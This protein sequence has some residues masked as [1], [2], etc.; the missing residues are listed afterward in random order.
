MHYF[1]GIWETFGH[2]IGGRKDLK[3]KYH[4]MENSGNDPVG[5]AD[6]RRKST[7]SSST[8]LRSKSEVA[9]AESEPPQKVRV[10]EESIDLASVEKPADFESVA[11]SSVSDSASDKENVSNVCIKGTSR[12]S[13]E[14]PDPEPS[15]GFE[16]GAEESYENESSDDGSSP[17]PEDQVPFPLPQTRALCYVPISNSYWLVLV[18]HGFFSLRWKRYLITQ[19]MGKKVNC[20]TLSEIGRASCRER[21]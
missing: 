4:D 16:E 8:S 15:S 21:V 9:A 17:I 20:I 5:V 10:I 3:R 7:R 18:G 12:P 6:C 2:S 14:N 1:D 19:R 11:D 13:E